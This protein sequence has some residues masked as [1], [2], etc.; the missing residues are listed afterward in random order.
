VDYPRH[1]G[2]LG[3]K[4]LHTSEFFSDLIEE[5]KLVP[6]EPVPLVITYQDPC[7]LGRLAGVFDAP[8]K[9]LAAIPDLDIIEVGPSGRDATCCGGPNGWVNCGQQTRRIQF[10]RFRTASSKGVDTIVTACPKCLIHYKC[11]MSSRMPAEH[12]KLVMEFM[13][14]NVLLDQATGGGGRP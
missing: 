3:F 6:S 13:D 8:R 4:V 14:I 11:A 2:E 1:F 10:D 12:E 5:G 7:R 9:V